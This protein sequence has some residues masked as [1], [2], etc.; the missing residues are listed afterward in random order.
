MQFDELMNDFEHELSQKLSNSLCI[1]K[2]CDNEDVAPVPG[3]KSGGVYRTRLVNEL[4]RYQIQQISH[5]Q[6]VE[7]TQNLVR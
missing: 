1:A 2:D 6:L 5:A 4:S 3:T 7:T